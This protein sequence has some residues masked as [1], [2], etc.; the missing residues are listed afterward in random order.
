[1]LDVKAELEEQ[2]A[3]ARELESGVDPALL[4][5]YEAIKKH[6]VPVVVRLVHGQCSGCNT[7]LPSATLSKIKNGAMVECETC[8]RMIIQ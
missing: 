2:R 3:K 6:T 5:Q 7:S 1:M 4:Q 8:G